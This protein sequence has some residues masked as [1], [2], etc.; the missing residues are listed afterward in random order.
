MKTGLSIKSEELF[1][2]ILFRQLKKYCQ[3]LNVKDLITKKFEKQ[4]VI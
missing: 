3:G 4:V 2:Q 1:V